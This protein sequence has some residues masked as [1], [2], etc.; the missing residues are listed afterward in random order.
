MKKFLI[1]VMTLVLTLCLVGCGK[2][3]DNNYI[4][5]SVKLH[6]QYTI[7]ITKVEA[8]D[9]IKIKETADGELVTKSEENTKYIAVSIKLTKADSDKEAYKLE[10]DTFKLKDHTGLAITKVFKK[11]LNKVKFTTTKAI[12]DYTWVGTKLEKGE[13]KEFTVYFYAPKV[14]TKDGEGNVTEIQYILPNEN[15]MIVEA[16]LSLLKTGVDIVLAPKTETTPENTTT[17]KTTT[18][19]QTTTAAPD[20]VE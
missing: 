19:E 16:D 20:P 2:N 17:T 18:A 9:E 10:E 7:T 13:T 14:E 12:K 15:L 5:D 4:G 6:R 11:D 3:K 1:L 8:V